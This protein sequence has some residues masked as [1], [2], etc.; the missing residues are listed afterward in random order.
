METTFDGN[1]GV[2]DAARGD[3]LQGPDERRGRPGVVPAGVRGAAAA[4]ARA[5]GFREL[6]GAPVAPVGARV[7]DT[8]PDSKR[9]RAASPSSG[10]ASHCDA[11]PTAVRQRV[12]RALVDT[13]VP[14]TLPVLPLAPQTQTL[15]PTETRAACRS[16]DPEL[17]ERVVAFA[18]VGED[19][20]GRSELH[21]T[22]RDDVLGGLSV[23]VTSFGGR[24]LGLNLSTSGGDGRAL[25]VSALLGGLRSR[26]LEVVD[27]QVE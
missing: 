8:A 6:F 23:R 14:V 25:D 5:G 24:R 18:G 20:A 26:G 3:E 10:A 13:Q 15:L 22:T 27:F 21:I 1:S 17:V 16:I 7:P 11:H 19:D 9:A 12:E 2:S 4:Q